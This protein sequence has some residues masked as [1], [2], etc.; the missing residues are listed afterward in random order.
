MATI[1]DD[2]TARTPPPLPPF[3]RRW[4]VALLVR[5]KINICSLYSD[6]MVVYETRAEL[7]KDIKQ[8]ALRKAPQLVN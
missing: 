1:L 4:G 2:I 8:L 3:A 5:P 7:D 6:K